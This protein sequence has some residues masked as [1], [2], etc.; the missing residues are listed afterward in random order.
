MIYWYDILVCRRSVVR[1][2]LTVVI[3]PCCDHSPPL[4]PA[5]LAPQVPE[6]ARSREVNLHPLITH[7]YI[8][9]PPCSK[10][11]QTAILAAVEM[12]MLENMDF[13]RCSDMLTDWKARYTLYTCITV[14]RQKGKR[15]G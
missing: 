4:S 12:H 2:L 3:V 10:E 5:G 7:P 13:M 9:V 11:E 8:T 14:D 6:H 1:L 15:T